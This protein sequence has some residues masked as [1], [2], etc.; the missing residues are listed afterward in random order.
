MDRHSEQSL[1]ESVACFERAIAKDAQFAA[2][3]AG[4]ADAY[5]LLA[6][7]G[8]VQPS[9]AM[10]TARAAAKQALTLD[11]GLAE[12]HVAL[13]A[14]IE[15]YDWNWA[16]AEREYRRAIELNPGASGGPS[17]VRHVPARPGP[18]GRG[19]RRIEASRA[20]GARL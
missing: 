6:Q 3:Y 16:A 8:Y 11:P 13:A 14:I 1:R 7:Y 5:N 15:A 2:A 9:E 12:G 18:A 4:L 19:D 17:L 10:E 20:A